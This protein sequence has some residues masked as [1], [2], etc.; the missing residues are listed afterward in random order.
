MLLSV[1][2]AFVALLSNGEPA[3][4]FGQFAYGDTHR[5][6]FFEVSPTEFTFLSGKGL[7]IQFTERTDHFA[8]RLSR[9][10]K[11]I[12]YRPRP[13]APLRLRFEATSL[14]FSL[15]YRDG[16]RLVGRGASAPFLT[17]AEGS[18]GPG[19][20]TPPTSW[21]LLSWGEPLP[22]VLLVFS[23]QPVALRA[24]E[25]DEGWRLESAEPYDGW[26]FVRAPLG[27][28]VV[29]ARSAADLGRLVAR[30]KDKVPTLGEPPRV[31]DTF[32]AGDARGVTVTWRFDRPGAVVPPPATAG[33]NER[34]LKVLSPIER[35]G[36]GDAF[37]CKGAELTIRF[38][39]RRL[40][41]GRSVVSGHP[42]EEE[43]AL[44][45]PRHIAEAALAYVWNTLS[46]RGEAEL[47]RSL[48]LW[49]SYAGVDREPATGLPWPGGRD[50]E[51]L[52]EYAALCFAERAL[53]S[54][55]E[56]GSALFASLDWLT[57][58]PTG[59]F[60]QAR[61][62]GAYLAL[63]GTVSEDAYERAFAAMAQAAL[64]A[65]TA[66]QP[67]D[68]L[69]GEVYPIAAVLDLAPP[70]R[71][72]PA[73]SPIRVFGDGVTVSLKEDELSLEGL[74]TKV[75]PFDVRLV[76]VSIVPEVS[77]KFNM[78]PPQMSFRDDAVLIK[79]SPRRVGYWKMSFRLAEAIV[80]TLPPAAP[81]PR[82]NEARRSPSAPVHAQR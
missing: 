71:L 10:D 54:T 81:S 68:S 31:I 33:A 24:I 3:P 27:E 2:L 34:Y 42:S 17:W 75:E 43:F 67:F 52:A 44:D 55:T 82:Y 26:V 32:A 58:L 77:A 40:F 15:E 38:I 8:Q 57:W 6:A 36:T 64:R 50:R 12:T 66:Q 62:A 5:L 51:S 63:V 56:R 20:P 65:G 47:R 69:R 28:E 73:L 80:R 14:G 70:A 30:V 13:A 22:P 61:E 59:E 21:A 74:V 79:L 37:R 7:R 72:Q 49:A 19:V 46:A 60:D 1:S 41:S 48:R 76:G 35:V 16:F 23:G 18:V 53:G 45:D 11:V 29:S 78:D 9:F 4:S 25:D 39:G